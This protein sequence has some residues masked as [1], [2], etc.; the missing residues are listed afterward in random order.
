[1]PRLVVV[2][3]FL[4]D[5]DHDLL[6]GTGDRLEC[7]LD[8]LGELFLDQRLHHFAARGQQNEAVD[9][10]DGLHRTQQR[11][12]LDRQRL[13]FPVAYVRSRDEHVDH[14]E[15][16]VVEVSAGSGQRVVL[17]VSVGRSG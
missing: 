16:G 4:R 6:R 9:L 2:P 14:L 15:P 12:V 3:G 5:G 8:A 13:R 10:P 1:M 11:L 17:R 7:A